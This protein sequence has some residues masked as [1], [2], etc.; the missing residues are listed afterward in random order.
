MAQ[1]EYQTSPCSRRDIR[2]CLYDYLCSCTCPEEKARQ[3]PIA[4]H[5]PVRSCG[6]SGRP[7]LGSLV[8]REKPNVARS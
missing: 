6:V 3:K 8:C 7:E 1:E 2:A 5:E 4:T